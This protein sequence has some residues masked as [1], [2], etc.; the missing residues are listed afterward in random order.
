[1]TSKESKLTQNVWLKPP[2]L[3]IFLS[4]AAAVLNVAD[5]IAGQMYALFHAVY[6]LGLIMKPIL[7]FA[8]AA[9]LILFIRS[10]RFTK[11]PFVSGKALSRFF[12]MQLIFVIVTILLY[13]D[14]P[15]AALSRMNSA[16]AILELGVNAIYLVALSG[17]CL[18]FASHLLIEKERKSLSIVFAILG[19]AFAA[20]FLNGIFLW[21]Q[22]YAGLVL[23]SQLGLI[24][25][26]GPLI[27]MFFAAMTA[28]TVAF[29]K[30]AADDASASLKISVSLLVP[31]FLV[32]PLW[33]S[34]KDGL[35]NFVFRDMFYYG[36]GYSSTQW[37]SVS[38]L[39]MSI[40]AY[41]IALRELSK[42]LKHDV[43]FGLIILGVASLPFNGI[44]P[45]TAGFSSIPG[46]VLSLSSIITGISLLNKQAEA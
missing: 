40:L 18:W 3:F 21:T 31:A 43:A 8:Q 36:F 30:A 29:M 44:V 13:V 24:G 19:L 39:L 38:F 34:F 9:L 26:F 10:I 46:N 32:P 12:G 22:S 25:T 17:T 33:D 37:Y 45:L 15:L 20:V 11:S 6:P 14:F 42:R 16:N 41:I 23:P 1:M 2:T 5:S 4:F 28:L 35:I 7:F 27:L